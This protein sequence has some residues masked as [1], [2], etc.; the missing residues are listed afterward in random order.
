MA[1]DVAFETVVTGAVAELFWDLYREAFEPLRTRAAARHVLHREEF[2]DELA[3]PRVTKLLARDEQG[4][5]VGL[6]TLATDLAAVPW[7]SPEFFAARYPEHAA[8]GAVWYI[9]FTL[10]HPGRRSTRTFMDMIDALVEHLARH[11]VVCAYDVSR[12][13]DDS[14]RFADNLRR[15]L[16]RTRDVTVETV[17]RQSYYAT[18]FH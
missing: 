2:D 5:P 8:R 14:L 15:H 11:R 16:E 4:T 1:A 6:T 10:A 17:D 13:N 3:D 18:T 9:G 12:F 7:V